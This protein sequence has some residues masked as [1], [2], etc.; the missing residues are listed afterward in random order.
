MRQFGYAARYVRVYSTANY[1]QT[2]ENKNFY[3]IQSLRR[4]QI[5]EEFLKVGRF[6]S[7]IS[8]KKVMTNT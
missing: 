4:R 1:S 8:S 3:N 6:L 2:I 5:S 7:V